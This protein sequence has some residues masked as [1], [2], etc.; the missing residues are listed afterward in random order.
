MRGCGL[1]RGIWKERNENGPTGQSTNFIAPTPVHQTECRTA[2]LS[3][4][5]YQFD[6][7]PIGEPHAQKPFPSAN[8]IIERRGRDYLGGLAGLAGATGTTASPGL[9]GGEVGNAVGNAVG[10]VAGGTTGAGI[11]PGMPSG[12]A[13]GEAG[14]APGLPV[15]VGSVAA[16]R[17]GTWVGSK[18]EFGPEFG[19]EGATAFG[20]KFVG[21]NGSTGV[22]LFSVVLLAAVGAERACG[23]AA[24]FSTIASKRYSTKTAIVKTVSA[25]PVLVPNAVCPELTPPPKA[26]A[27]P[28]PCGFW[29]RTV[30]TITTQTAMKRNISSPVTQAGQMNARRKGTWREVEASNIAEPNGCKI[31]TD[32]FLRLARTSCPRL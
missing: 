13:E 24:K 12:V 1:R 5:G 22:A 32:T 25:S 2:S 16:G 20:S 4:S 29:M 26:L 3:S 23:A 6:G 31:L 28:P 17:T 18:G 14:A 11:V 30:R 27:N 10:E 21:A 9:G 8:L 19:P 7:P 15:V